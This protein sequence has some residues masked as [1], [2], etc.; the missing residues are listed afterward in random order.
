MIPL[1]AVIDL[2]A[3][4]QRRFTRY[5]E[6]KR[7]DTAVFQHAEGADPETFAELLE[8]FRLNGLPKETA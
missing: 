5:V 2:N 8:D 4:G 1:L 7:H 3:A 6:G